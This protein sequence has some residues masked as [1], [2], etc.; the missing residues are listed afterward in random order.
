MKRLLWVLLFVV[1]IFG[2]YTQKDKLWET[3]RSVQHD[4]ESGVSQIEDQQT[5]PS[6]T[7]KVRALLRDKKY[8]E[9]N[10]YLAKL[11]QN[12]DI[13]IAAERELVT[14]YLVFIMEDK[15]LEPL[16][17]E[18]VNATP[19]QS[20]PYLARA[21]YYY[22]LGWMAR[23]DKWASETKKENMQE[24]SAYFA[25][26]MED[27]SESLKINDRSMVPYVSLISITN[28]LGQSE[29]TDA[30]VDK[31]LEIN[32]ASYVVRAAYLHSLTPRWGGSYEEMARF[33][34][35]SLLYIRRNPKLAWLEGDI[36][37]D[38]GSMSE[39]REAPHAAEEQYTKALSFGEYHSVLFKRGK[40][41]CRLEKYQDALAD[42]NRAIEIYPEAAR[43]YYW[44]AATYI[45]LHDNERAM[46]D[47]QYAVK[48]DPYDKSIMEKYE[49]LLL[50]KGYELR[51]T[52]NKS[53]EIAQ[54]N[55]ALRIN[56]NN[57]ETYARRAHAY[58]AQN[59]NDLALID[60]DKAIEIDPNNIDYYIL[61]D[62]VL[63]KTHSWEKIIPYWDK[64]I[65]LNPE[66]ARAYRERGGTYFRMGDMK[67][68]VQNAKRAAE[69][70][71][72][73]GKELY[74][75]YRGRVGE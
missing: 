74:E 13:D 52:S 3:P 29:Q 46:Q 64:Y 22:G 42:L 25:K 57:A 70:G 66:N 47:I 43:Y 30:V 2:A 8:E 9:L 51:N 23:G 27:I 35:K 34:E 65:A 15:S 6:I 14:A 21:K 16:F 53:L 63:A 10:E 24:M 28:T 36:Y 11:Q 58:V 7:L 40:V 26:A 38:M 39:I 17:N 72:L 75:R 33:V 60:L 56:P 31:A 32:P 55:E 37:T 68:A 1:C 44:R 18:W 20:A 48:L 69:L 4:N 12:A 73:Q 45:G 19:D 50:V 67:T 5:A 61:I 59:K 62:F 41:R 71:D 54:Y 49:W